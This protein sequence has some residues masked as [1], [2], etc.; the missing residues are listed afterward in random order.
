VIAALATV[1]AVVAG[2]MVWRTPAPLAARMSI[3]LPPGHQVTS[4]PII[5]RDGSR[6][7]FASGSGI[8]EPRLY[9]RTM[10]SFE[11]KE[12]PGTEGARR[13][14]FSPDG[15]WV[16]FFAKG[17]LFKLDLG[18]GVPTPLADAPSP[19]GGTWAEDDTIVFAPTWNGGLYRVMASGLPRQLVIKPDPAK[20]EYAYVSPRFLPGGRTLLFSVWGAAF[21][22]E[23]LTLAD[24]RREVVAPG[25]W[26]NTVDTTSGHLLLGS[27]EGDVKA[28]AYPSA[29]A[30]GSGIT[31]LEGVHWM[32][33]SGDGLFKMA[34]S[35][36]GTLV[37]APG[38]IT[39]RSLAIVDETG[40][41]EPLPGEP[42]IYLSAAVSPD[43]RQAATE[44]GG[45][46]W[47]VDLERG[48]RTPIASSHRGGAQV[49]PVWA[50][51]GSRVYFASNVEGNWEIYS[52]QVARP[53]MVE[54]VLAK[55]FD[56]F[57]TAVAADGTL[58]FD[59][60]RP[61]MG[62]DV[63]VMPSG[64][65]PVAWL[66]TPAEE[67]WATLSP[68]GRLVAY[69]SNAS[70]RV[71]VFV[72]TREGGAG[73]VQIS[74]NG[75]AEPVWAP[76]GNRIFF[77]EGN[78]VMAATVQAGSGVPDGRPELLFDRGW[79]LPAGVGL[80]VLPDGKRFLMIRFAP[81]AIPTRLDVV[82]NWFDD[83]RARVK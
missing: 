45:K 46:L 68:D 24:L 3:S 16:G 55:E 25:S 6:I 71:E 17:R 56:Q 69:A 14:F 10:E 26:T 80:S 41:A 7:V 11:L 59:E 63:W 42:Q 64:G 1:L 51:D 57:P 67:E 22:V 29:A 77:R 53:E 35:D 73:G 82:F 20:K 28:F 54:T 27:N 74:T 8:G 5:S 40:R 83:L 34:V 58:F 9:L 70:G 12:L 65:A 60:L 52:V 23:Q 39:Q 72:R 48:G 79:E 21:N 36:G 33:G 50:R 78:A 32:G 19:G 38:D 4:G 44:Q 2:V 76:T 30:A 15:R 75:G 18:G 49:A 66:A 37:Y 62:T 13:P 43:G 47:L 31:V 61:G 81:A